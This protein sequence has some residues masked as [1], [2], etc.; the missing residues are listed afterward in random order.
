MSEP[1][2]IFLLF[3]PS[4]LLGGDEQQWEQYSEVGTCYL[5]QVTMEEMEYLCDRP[6]DPE[7][8]STAWEFCRFMK[9]S[10]WQTTNIRR[11]HP[12]LNPLAD[13]NLSQAARFQQDFA[14][15]AYGL[16]WENS[17]VLVVLVSNNRN[18][19]TK[20]EAL[21]IKNITTI[22]TA[23]LRQW[24]SKKQTPINVRL[25]MDKQ[26][27]ANKPEIKHPTASTEQIHL[28]SKSSRLSSKPT[29]SSSK[30]SRPSSK[31]T[32]SSSKS[33]R[34]SSKVFSR[35][36]RPLNIPP[37]HFPE[38]KKTNIIELLI[39][40]ISAIV[41]FAIAGFLMWYLLQPDSLN[42]FL[43]EQGLPTIKNDEST[44]TN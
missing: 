17:D 26:V 28:F 42:E 4:V 36:E 6:E 11:V 38:R 22:S 44:T 43:E 3:E 8:E 19:T 16:A 40:S 7:Q 29:R 31:P 23:N 1:I 13:E 12:F 35:S 34:L 15:L 9:E 41:A 14:E 37:S 18:L 24:V 25:L 33:S 27:K 21:A 5:P 20:I 32:H 10:D 39:P 2:S 30:P